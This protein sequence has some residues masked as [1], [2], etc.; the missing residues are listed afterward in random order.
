VDANSRQA[1]LAFVLNPLLSIL[2][3]AL[4]NILLNRLLKPLHQNMSAQGLRPIK[5]VVCR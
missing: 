1:A 3:N 2:L 4:L 5:L